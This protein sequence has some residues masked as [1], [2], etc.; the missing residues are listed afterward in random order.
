MSPKKYRVRICI[1]DADLD[2]NDPH[3]YTDEPLMENK[4]DISAQA[5]R[6]QRY[7]LEGN[8]K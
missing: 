6:T 2:H 3:T 5:L 8:D 4:N 1:Y 7:F